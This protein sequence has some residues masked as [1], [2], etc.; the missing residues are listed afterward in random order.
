MKHDAPN[1]LS[2]LVIQNN[3]NE[4][5]AAFQAIDSSHGFEDFPNLSYDKLLIISLGLYQME[6]AKYCW[7]VKDKT[8]LVEV[9][10]DDLEID[11]N[12][13][14]FDIADVNTWNVNTCLLYHVMCIIWYLYV[15]WTRHQDTSIPP[16]A[17]FLDNVFRLEEDDDD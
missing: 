14:Q 7:Y 15:A 8:F 1:C 13:S 5:T 6:Q 10:E 4:H 11:Y 3:F 17:D 16:P 9:Y 2:A 12:L